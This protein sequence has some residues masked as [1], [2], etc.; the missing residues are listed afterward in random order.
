MCMCVTDIFTADATGGMQ[1]N[2]MHRV[3]LFELLS[4]EEFIFCVNTPPCV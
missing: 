1:P 2:Y 4:V 3:G